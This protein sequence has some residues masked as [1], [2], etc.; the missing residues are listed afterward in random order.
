MHNGNHTRV[1]PTRPRRSSRRFTKG[2]VEPADLKVVFQHFERQEDGLMGYDQFKA[3][4]DDLKLHLRDH[5]VKRLFRHLCTDKALA[6]TNSTWALYD[7]DDG[8]SVST[9][10]DEAMS[11]I[12]TSPRAAAAG[13]ECRI[14]A[15]QF[16]AGIRRHRFLRRIVSLYTFNDP[17]SWSV[18]RDYDYSKPTHENYGRPGGDDVGSLV[19]IR[20]RLDRSWHGSYVAER[21]LWQD[22]VVHAVAL[23]DEAIKESRRYHRSNNNNGN[24]QPSAKSGNYLLSSSWSSTTTSSSKLHNGRFPCYPPDKDDEP[25]D[26]MPPPPPVPKILVEKDLNNGLVP[27]ETSSRLEKQHSTGET[28]KRVQRRPSSSSLAPSSRPWLVFTCGAMGAGKGYVMNWMSLRDILPLKEVVVHVD[29]DKFKQMMPEWPEYVRRDKLGAGSMCHKESG[30]LA[31]LA[32]E[33]AMD[34]SFNVWVDGSLRDFEWHAQKI[35]QIRIRHPQYRIALFYVHASEATVRKRVKTRAARLGGRD[36]PED[37][38]AASLAA[39][40]HTLS[41]LTP[42]VDFVARILNEDEPVLEAVETV[43]TTGNWHH[44]AD[45]F[46]GNSD[47]FERFGSSANLLRRHRTYSASSFSSLASSD[48]LDN[49]LVAAAAATSSQAGSNPQSPGGQGLVIGPFSYGRSGGLSAMIAASQQPQHQ[50]T[51]SRQEPPLAD[52]VTRST[53]SAGSSDLSHDDVSDL[54][55]RCRRESRLLRTRCDDDAKTIASLRAEVVHLRHQ[56][57]DKKDNDDDD[58]RG[59][60]DDDGPP[61]TRAITACFRRGSSE[62]I[63]PSPRSRPRPFEFLRCSFFWW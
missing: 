52:P 40:A 24:T 60:D 19:E 46:A 6:A 42:M 21:Q 5:E 7:E 50:T 49:L 36:I 11:V 55:A 8:A 61:L 47:L 35:R 17:R 37:V 13:I 43:D 2:I 45:M 48:R 14:N 44:I 51:P 10:D 34:Q 62:R 25:K 54:L 58:F 23:P 4:V 30:L 38:L 28:S 39:P 41:A 22:A 16:L 56:L 57:Q 18:P 33:L 53:G 12:P 32:Q 9:A 3:L 15:E 31:E 20:R 26:P 63:A 59:V 1:T 27:P 29:P